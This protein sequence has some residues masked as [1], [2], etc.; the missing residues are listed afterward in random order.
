[1]ATKTRFALG[2]KVYYTG[3]MA[4][5]SGSGEVVKITPAD[6]WGG[7]SY[8]IQLEDGGYRWPRIGGISFKATPGR[9]FWALEEWDEDQAFRIN[10]SRDRMLA[11]IAAR[12]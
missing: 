12:A 8:D 7:E 11:A 3:D 1:M 4:N 2:D 9:R 10:E 6:K 5:A